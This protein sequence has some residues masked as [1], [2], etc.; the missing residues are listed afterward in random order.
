MTGHIRRH[1]HK[2][3]GAKKDIEGSGRMMS[4]NVLNTCWPYGIH[5]AVQGRVEIAS[6]DHEFKV[7]KIDYLVQSSLS[8]SLV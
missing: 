8:S 5:M 1:G 7:Y 3:H 4:Y 6:M 2:S